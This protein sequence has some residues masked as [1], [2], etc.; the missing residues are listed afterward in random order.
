MGWEL[1]CIPLK[2]QLDG[3]NCGPW[4]HAALELFVRYFKEGASYGDV[5]PYVAA[6]F[7]L[8]VGRVQGGTP[9]GATTAVNYIRVHCIGDPEM[10]F[11]CS[12]WVA[13]GIGG[14][15]GRPSNTYMVM[16]IHAGNTR[17]Y[18]AAPLLELASS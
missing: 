2:L 11:L 10:R 1:V 7:E 8:P 6:D 12:V 18:M 14:A 13:G 3:W 16:P 5:K 17:P 9:G 4:S 15:R